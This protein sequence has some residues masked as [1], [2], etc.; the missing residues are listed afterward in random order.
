MHDTSACVRC[1]V[2][3]SAHREH[4]CAAGFRTA[5]IVGGASYEVQK[6]KLRKGAEIVVATPGRLLDCLQKRYAVLNQC[7]Y[8]VLDE[9]DRMIDLGFEPQVID[10]LAAMPASN[11]K[12]LE[13]EDGARMACP[14]RPYRTTYMFSATMPPAVERIA[15]RYLRRPV[16]VIVGSAGRA[17]DSVSQR[18]EWM[19]RKQKPGALLRALDTFQ[20]ETEHLSQSD[21]AGF[22][23]IC[24]VNNRVRA[25]AACAPAAACASAAWRCTTHGLRAATSLGLCG[26]R[27]HW[28]RCSAAHACRRT[29]RMCTTSWPR[30]GAT[31]LACCT[32]AS[33][34][35][36]ARSASRGSARASTMS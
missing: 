1:R 9:A 33:L 11:M 6:G 26:V 5:C 21:N 31:T 34:R 20:S 35:S 13:E 32:V 23:V 8:V 4:A 16:T 17:T 22:K 24:F 30:R 36:S 14:V 15:K 3:N 29:A 25:A 7:A 27:T 18:V 12:P 28:S 2:Q 10:V 19:D